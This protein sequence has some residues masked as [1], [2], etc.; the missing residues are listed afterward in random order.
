MT[1][2]FIKKRL[3]GRYLSV[4]VLIVTT[5]SVTLSTLDKNAV[6]LKQE[7]QRN[8]LKKNESDALFKTKSYRNI[9]LNFT[10]V[11][12]N[13]TSTVLLD[14]NVSICTQ[15]RDEPPEDV[16]EWLTYYRL[17]YNVIGVCIINDASTNDYTEIFASFSVSTIPSRNDRNQNFDLCQK[18]LGI[19]RDDKYA[20]IFITDVD[21]FLLVEQEVRFSEYVSLFNQ[22]SLNALNHGNDVETREEHATNFSLVLQHTRR[23]PHYC[24]H[25][26]FNHS[27][28][29]RNGCWYDTVKSIVKNSAVQQFLTHT[30][31]VNGITIP[32]HCNVAAIHHY[33]IRSRQEFQS[34]YAWEQDSK[35]NVHSKYQ[36]VLEN[37]NHYT[38]VQD[39][40]V[41]EH[42]LQTIPNYA[43]VLQEYKSALL[44]NNETTNEKT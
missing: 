9:T 20:R 7:D 22:V 37:I 21:E 27:L 17:V 41:K 13:R 28:S 42:V 25:E 3:F 18:C 23:A 8:A 38:S 16:I 32:I 10:V 24:L 14:N 39:N 35:W 15:I 33:F 12:T 30:S 29:C 6:Q 36:H 4:F 2:R 40:R 43:M 34:K 44:L 26:S 1:E 5:A 11:K 19:Q 31:K